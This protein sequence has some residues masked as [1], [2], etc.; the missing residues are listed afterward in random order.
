[1][2][3]EINAPLLLFRSTLTFSVFV[4]VYS[5]LGMWRF[6]EAPRKWDPGGLNHFGVPYP[7]IMMFPM[8]Q[9]RWQVAELQWKESCADVVQSQNRMAGNAE[10]VRYFLNA[11]DV[12]T[13]DTSDKLNKLTVSQYSDSYH[14]YLKGDN[15]MSPTIITTP[16]SDSNK[17]RKAGRITSEN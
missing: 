10:R 2:I 8:A 16:Q 5:S 15:Q 6:P 12:S 3:T 1:M 9:L 4:V 7:S 14:D 13:Q 17:S 11:P